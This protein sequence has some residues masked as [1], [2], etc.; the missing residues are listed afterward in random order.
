M[1]IGDHL[2]LSVELLNVRHLLG[3]LPLLDLLNV[4]LDVQLLLSLLQE[5]VPSAI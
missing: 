5:Q 2:A 1:L 4:S 3:L